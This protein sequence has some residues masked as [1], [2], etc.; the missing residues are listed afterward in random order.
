[1]VMDRM[2]LKKIH[3]LFLASALVINF[4]AFAA[5]IPQSPGE[6]PVPAAPSPEAT[7]NAESNATANAEAKARSEEILR[8]YLQ[9]QE[10]LHSAMLAIEQ[11]RNQADD[12][13]RRNVE[14]ISTRLK[15]IE[16]ALTA[17]RERE[18]VVADKS[19][20]LVLLVAGIFGGMGLLAM[21]ITAWFQL[22]AMN[23]LAQMSAA[24]GP[25]L[26]HHPIG[27][28]GSGEVTNISALP[29]TNANSNLL[30]AIERLEKRFLE[31]QNATRASLPT[32]TVTHT[33]G[34]P[35]VTEFSDGS[36]GG[37]TGENADRLSLL[38][39]KS[40]AL[41]N[42][43]QLDEALKSLNEALE[44]EPDNAEALVKKGTALERQKKLEEAIDCYDRAIAANSGMTLAYLCKGGVYNQ[45]ERFSEAL[46]CY[47]QALRTQQ[48]TSTAPAAVA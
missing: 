41:L 27:S 1:L 21:V 39:G 31:L 14:T 45:L 25:M 15:L 7:S 33:N 3:G 12:A 37:G 11:N 19:Q 46:E 8:S 23:R 43:D 22:R 10:Q 30:G 44:I 34:E 6:T 40:Q 32:H 26:G 28:L 13:A 36:E 9:I 47:E 20:R 35:S 2:R 18:A 48:K 17:E 5:D 38:L 29:V 16:Q 42:M 4:S 24:G